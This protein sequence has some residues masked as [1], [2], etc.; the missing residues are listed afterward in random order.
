[1]K[2][3]TLAISI[4]AVILCFGFT[5]AALA[6]AASPKGLVLTAIDNMNFEH[7]Q[8]F[9]NQS[10]GT[11]TF[12]VDK[13]GG[14]SLKEVKIPVG[15]SLDCDIKLDV[16]GKKSVFDLNLKYNNKTYQ[17]Q[18]Y[19]AGDKLIFTK[20]FI[21]ALQELAPQSNLDIPD[22][23]PEYLY[24]SDSMLEQPLFT[25][26]W[27]S[28]LNYPNDKITEE[29]K[30]LLKFFVEAIPEE[31]FSTSGGTVTL[32][33]DQDGFIATINAV[34]QKVK[35]EKERF[36]EIIVTL[37][38]ASDTTGVMGSPEQMKAEIIKGIDD[39]V[40][41]GA[42]PTED[43][44]KMVGM[45]IQVNQLKYQ[46][47][48]IPG[49]KSNFNASIALKPETGFT[50]QIDINSESAGKTDNLTSAYTFE[51]K[52]T[53]PDG[54]S[55]NGTFEGDMT[56]KDEEMTQNMAF[57]ATAQKAG[58]MEFDVAISS[59]STQQV[60]DGINISVPVLTDSN[61]L[62]IEKFIETGKNATV[63]VPEGESNI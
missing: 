34:M 31:Y 15:T 18:A 29:S 27:T 25:Q 13:F 58:A 1:M 43:Q 3:K 46:T 28:M 22:Q 35:D 23:L 9:Y 44:V 2:R 38:T 63:K 6:A 42:W 62:N 48:I 36:A 11:M 54:L 4:L 49:G 20:S 61:S 41:N 16:P 60:E 59:Q 37:T 7:N 12:T 17:G 21:T 19:L 14:N 33:L 52:F 10:S 26:I 40:K 51:L 5:F 39:A 45:F 50:G 57:S 55:F 30:A 32:E 53:G 47:A 56:V 24:L 8:K